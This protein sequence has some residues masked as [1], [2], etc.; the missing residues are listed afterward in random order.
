MTIGQVAHRTNFKREEPGRLFGGHKLEE[1]ANSN[2]AA[3]CS[4]CGFESL[5]PRSQ[6]GLFLKSVLS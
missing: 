6:N 1:L 4:Q 2:L 5:L 3:G